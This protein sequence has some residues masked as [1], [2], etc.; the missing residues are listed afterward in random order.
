MSPILLISFIF[1]FVI[2]VSSLLFTRNKWEF[3]FY[4]LSFGLILTPSTKILGLYSSNPIN[5]NINQYIIY[6][7]ILFYPISFLILLK[8]KKS[9]K[10]ILQYYYKEFGI[11]F[12]LIICSFLINMILNVLYY[13]ISFFAL[14]RYHLMEYVS[15][16]VILHFTLIL[17][18]KVDSLRLNII[19]RNIW[20]V[21]LIYSATL[22]ILFLL[23]VPFVTSLQEVA[24]N[25]N[26]KSANS[27]LDSAIDAALYL[28]RSYSIFAGGNQFG[29]LASISLIIASYFFKK[30]IISKSIF[31]LII[32]LQLLI[33]TSSLS[34]TGFL[35]YLLACLIIFLRS[36]KN[37]YKILLFITG[38]SVILYLT[39][40][41]FDDR[42]RNIFVF[43]K[44]I[45]AFISER[46]NHWTSF[47]EILKTNHES[48]YLGLSKQYLLS[49]NIFFENGY[50]NLYAEGGIFTL[51]I[52][53]LAYFIL[54]Y[55]LSK[56]SQIDSFSS[57]SKTSFDYLFLFLLVELLQGVLFS[58]RFESLN[59]ITIAYFIYEKYLS[60]KIELDNKLT[61][62]K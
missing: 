61:F 44:F 36:S 8:Q 52:H 34:R 53:F 24:Y 22:G 6:L 15:F 56:P 42:I 14:P 4:I 11:F 20:I 58:F 33:L 21:T 50:L 3:L 49:N 26:F 7:L 45:A 16:F 40:T 47:F 13:N 19:F 60:H 5:F 55:K 30:R 32:F 48:I 29:I 10:N 27:F 37:I 31:I 1:L 9:A 38:F 23:K 39:L 17:L 28:N 25:F 12:F 62:T 54:I 51:F 41:L 2:V 18:S 57:I 43:D 46:Y 59:G 35:F